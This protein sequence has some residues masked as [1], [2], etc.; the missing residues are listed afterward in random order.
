M[1]IG[2]AGSFGAGKGEVVWETTARPCQLVGEHL[3]TTSDKVYSVCKTP[4]PE[5]TLSNLFNS[6][7]L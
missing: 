2:I 4:G 6:T 5:L 3:E 1:V 7:V